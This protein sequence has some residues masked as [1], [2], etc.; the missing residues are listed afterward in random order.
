[1][2]EKHILIVDDD[3]DTLT[4]LETILRNE[5][6]KVHTASNKKQAMEVLDKYDIDLAILDV[7]MDSVYEGFELAYYL[8]NDCEL[9]EIPVLIQTSMDVFDSSNPDD[10]ALARRYRETMDSKDIEVLFV[11]NTVTGES[12]IDYRN[13]QG[14]VIWIPVEGFIRKPVTAANLLPEVKRLIEL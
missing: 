4:I 3:I 12:G 9:K 5:G 14:K 2:A 1:M 13:E 8:K 10:L 6:Y 11:Q 7:M